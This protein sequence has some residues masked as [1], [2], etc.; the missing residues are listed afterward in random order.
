M[1]ET[2]RTTPSASEAAATQVEVIGLLHHERVQRVLA[3]IFLS[4]SSI[5][6]A[7]L[8][9]LSC[10]VSFSDCIKCSWTEEVLWRYAFSRR[11]GREL[12][13]RFEL[14]SMLSPSPL[15]VPDDDS[16]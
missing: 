4:S 13:I 11:A 6:L 16:L 7:S 9:C 3:L 10:H 15:S 5:S 12:G 2:S 1:F 8:A 14:E